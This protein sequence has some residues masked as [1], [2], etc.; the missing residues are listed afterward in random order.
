MK[1][2]LLLNGEPYKKDIC[3]DNARTVCCDGAYLWAKG[4]VRIDENVGDFDSLSILPDPPPARIYPSE[5]NFTD[6]EIGLERLLSFGCD[7]IEIYGTGGGRE[8]HFLG[9]L[10]L[11]YR[12]LSG[13]AR[14]T[15][16]TNG[17]RIYAVFD[18]FFLYGQTGKTISLLPFGGEA[19]IINSRGL[20][21]PLEDLTLSYG[22]C[23]GISNV[24]I[25]AEAYFHCVSGMV[26][27]FVNE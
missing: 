2:I 25:S 9:N 13:G 17:A 16:F 1:G 21:Y 5:K 27:V 3:A 12:A 18:E 6:G 14:V 10:H 8:D 4:K 7:E 23:R 26:L 20:K 22:S 19:H 24:V 11:L 15:A